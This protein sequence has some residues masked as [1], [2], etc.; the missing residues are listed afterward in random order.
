MGNGRASVARPPPLVP[1]PPPPPPSLTMKCAGA[2]VVVV[3]VVGGS[4]KTKNNSTFEYFP[5]NN[6]IRLFLR[7]TCTLAPSRSTPPRR[8]RGRPPRA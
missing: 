1:C 8:T 4:L 6:T 7:P 2:S 3:V 5:H